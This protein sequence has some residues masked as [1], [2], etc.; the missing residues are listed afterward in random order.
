MSG[1]DGGSSNFFDTNV[2]LYLLSE[3]HSKADKAEELLSA[4]GVV[5]VQVLNEF[6][7]VA[8]WKFAMKWGEV[9]DCLEPFR[10]VL[11]IEPLTVDTHDQALD[12]AERCKV[13]FYDALIIAAAKLAGCTRLYSE[14]LQHRQVFEK[15]L[16]VVNP[17]KG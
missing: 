15:S 11:R 4:G 6:A 17:F 9:R 1:V 7:T 16:T 5:S 12:I 10:L 13:S 14:D 3:D 8:S 2:L